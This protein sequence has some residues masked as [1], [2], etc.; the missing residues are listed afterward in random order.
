VSGDSFELTADEVELVLAYRRARDEHGAAFTIEDA[1]AGI[2]WPLWE[3]VQAGW[4]AVERELHELRGTS[5]PAGSV[6]AACVRYL[7]D[8]D[9]ASTFEI[10][11][12]LGG[13]WHPEELDHAMGSCP[14]WFER[15]ADRPPLPCA[16]WRLR[17]HE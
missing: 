1:I 3:R 11:D 12:A 4:D 15:L 16:C 5:R 2:E 6:T 13:W 7:A 14:H 9:E 17:R 10:R 8:V